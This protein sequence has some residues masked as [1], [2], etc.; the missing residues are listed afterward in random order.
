MTATEV[1]SRS[2]VNDLIDLALK[3]GDD[4]VG[5]VDCAAQ[6]HLDLAHRA[7]DSTAEIALSSAP[8]AASLRACRRYE[9]MAAS[10]IPRRSA[11]RSR[12]LPRERAF[13]GALRLH[14]RVSFFKRAIVV[15]HVGARVP[16]ATS[17]PLSSAQNLR[18]PLL[19]HRMPMLLAVLVAL[20]FVGPNRPLFE[21]GNGAIQPA[22]D[23][24]HLQLAALGGLARRAPGS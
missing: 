7:S 1:S 23:A 3:P 2:A 16:C 8:S 9:A 21:I 13:G 15:S 20:E 17:R 4:L 22:A 24:L 18:K 10:A 14:I 12:T 19:D 5:V 11:A 6:G